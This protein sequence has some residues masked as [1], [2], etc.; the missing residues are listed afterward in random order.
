M[1][2]QTKIELPTLVG[3]FE[4]EEAKL[5][6]KNISCLIHHHASHKK[7]STH[8]GKIHLENCQR[9]NIGLTI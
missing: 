6:M 8:S 7:R 3:Q 1:I 5:A 2:C 4:T 9:F